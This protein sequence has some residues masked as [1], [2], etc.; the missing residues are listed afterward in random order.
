[1]EAGL[2]LEKTRARSPRWDFLA[3]NR[4]RFS[5]NARMKIQYLNLDRKD[6][7]KLLA[8]RRQAASIIA[9]VT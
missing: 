4:E 7:S 2:G 1:M 5:S 8:I 6:R 3:R 9:I